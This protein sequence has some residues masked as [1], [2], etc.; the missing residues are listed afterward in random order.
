MRKGRKFEHPRLLTAERQDASVL[1]KEGEEVFSIGVFKFNISAMLDWLKNNPQPIVEV[2]VGMLGTFSSK[3][4]RYVDLA[5][6]SR[7]IVIAE[8]A[9]DYRD[10]VPDI[11]EKDLI[12]RGYVCIDG[13]HR[14][15][16]AK[17]VGLETLPAVVI[18]MEQHIHFIY[19]GYDRYVE[20]WN[21]KL[22]ER[23]EDALRWQRRTNA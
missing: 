6:I 7:P 4:D 19:S 1:P 17:R 22:K 21:M 16:K 13:Q 15:E 20:Y 11:S 9:P 5:D 14:I 23:C 10:F 18:R 12:T 2:S 8:I 3:E